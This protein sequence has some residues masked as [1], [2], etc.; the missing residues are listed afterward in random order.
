ML[1]ILA[2]LAAALLLTFLGTQDKRLDQERREAAMGLATVALKESYFRSTS[3]L[4]ASVKSGLEEKFLGRWLV[5]VRSLGVL[6]ATLG[7]HLA[8]VAVDH[9]A[10]TSF[11][12]ERTGFIIFHLEE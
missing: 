12:V 10:S 9:V 11:A 2:L 4:A 6:E 3:S 8:G 5:I 7:W 1:K